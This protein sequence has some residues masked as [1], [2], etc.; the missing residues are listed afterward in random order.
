M[1]GIFKGW[2]LEQNTPYCETVA[3]YNAGREE[4]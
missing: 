1:D 4:Y 2:R 3:V